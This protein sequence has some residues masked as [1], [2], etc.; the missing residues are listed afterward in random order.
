MLKASFPSFSKEHILCFTKSS[1]ILCYVLIVT[2]IIIA[3]V[4]IIATMYYFTSL[5][6]CGV[7][8]IPIS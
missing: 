7:I 5:Y 8:I 1:H 3:F 4:N 2:A 6:L